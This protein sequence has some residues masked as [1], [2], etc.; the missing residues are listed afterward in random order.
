MCVSFLL[1]K[2][3]M[4]MYNDEDDDEDDARG[5]MMTCGGRGDNRD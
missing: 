1:V 4:K 5:G 2:L 3:S